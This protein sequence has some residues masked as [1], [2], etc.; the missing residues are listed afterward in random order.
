VT[1][2]FFPLFE[3]VLGEDYQDTL[4][5]RDNLGSRNSLAMSHLAAGRTAKAIRLYER[6]LADCERVLGADH[7]DTLRSRNNLAMSYQAA[8]R[9]AEAI[10][11]LER[12]LADCERVLGADHPDTKA[13]R[14]NLAALT[15]KPERHS[16]I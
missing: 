15:G 1:T 7:K 6:T 5:A 9:T 14:E 13:V 2:I 12:T 11:L 8:G 3:W 10:P 4:R 16:H